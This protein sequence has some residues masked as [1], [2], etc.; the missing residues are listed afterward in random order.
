MKSFG[1]RWTTL[2]GQCLGVP[3]SE[4]GVLRRY[5]LHL[6]LVDAFI[7]SDLQPLINTFKHRRWSQPMLG[8]SQLV[9]GNLGL[10]VN[11]NE[12]VCVPLSVYSTRI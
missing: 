10:G 1:N 4:W 3:P 8:D 7:Q 2:S 6:H 11:H 5:T 9:K 12:Q